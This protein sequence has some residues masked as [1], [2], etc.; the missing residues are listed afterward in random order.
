MSSLA[1]II[2]NVIFFSSHLVFKSEIRSGLHR[3]TLLQTNVLISIDKTD[4]SAC[5][6]CKWVKSNKVF[7][8]EVIHFQKEQYLCY[9]ISGTYFFFILGDKMRGNIVGVCRLKQSQCSFL[10]LCI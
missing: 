7:Y 6:Y 3:R 8:K 4:E 9:K 5:I 2:V 1:P 10:C